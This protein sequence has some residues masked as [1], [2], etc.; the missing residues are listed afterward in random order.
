MN[1]GGK[2]MRKLVI[3]CIGC[4]FGITLLLQLAE[5]RAYR[6]LTGEEARQLYGGDEYDDYAL[7]DGS[8]NCV[9]CSPDI[10]VT[11]PT[12]C[13]VAEEGNDGCFESTGTDSYCNTFSWFSDCEYKGGIQSCGGP[14]N[15]RACNTMRWPA[16]EGWEVGQNPAGCQAGTLSVQ[17]CQNCATIP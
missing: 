3:L 13:L 6:L 4:G 17:Q 9:K 1:H 11:G 7:C 15:R 8:S 2:S 10:C 16:C 12:V 14:K 5:P